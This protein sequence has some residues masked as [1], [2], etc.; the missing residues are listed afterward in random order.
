[1]TRA[2]GGQT[3][4]LRKYSQGRYYVLWKGGG[5]KKEDERI[6]ALEL[7]IE[8]LEAGHRALKLEWELVYDKMGRLMGRLNARIRKADAAA[9]EEEPT[10][11]T[12]LPAQARFGTHGQMQMARMRRGLL[13]R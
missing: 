9:T 8:G 12:A 1:M 7:R 11:E 2:G 4:D 10:P 3:D 6:R 5:R 13:P